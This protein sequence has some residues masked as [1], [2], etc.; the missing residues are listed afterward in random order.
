MQP[1]ALNFRL[2]F[3]MSFLFL[4][5]GVQLPF[6]PL[7]LADRGLSTAEI[8]AVLSGQILIRT[9][10]APLGTFL[11]DRYGR[12]ILL[13]RLG[14]LLCAA[15]YFLLD[16]MTGFAAIFLVAVLAS[17]FLS[18]VG[19]IAENFAIV[20]SAKRGLD[21]GRQRLWAS[22]SFIIGTL[23]S[24]FALEWLDTSRAV[25]LIAV[26]YLALAA[27]GFVLPDQRRRKSKTEEAPAIVRPKDVLQ[28]FR[29]RSFVIFLVAV[30]LA[31]ASHAL[32]YGFGSL[33]WEQLG[34]AKATIGIL[35]GIGVVAEVVFFFFSGRL[36]PS[37]MPIAL[38]IAGCLAGVLRWIVTAF[39]PA[40]WLLMPLQVLHA[41]TFALVHFGTLHFLMQN[42]PE[43]LRNS[44]QGLY[45]ACSAG[46]FMMIATAIAGPLFDAFAGGA[47]LAMAVM[48]AL[49][50]A[51]AVQ[52]MRISPRVPAAA[53]TSGS[54]QN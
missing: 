42:V 38:I 52:V 7:W 12:P 10:G 39:D 2:C 4:G 11:A 24:G 9:F 17:V 41:L 47:Y 3:Y 54:R 20:E 49:A 28:L 31:Q 33:H 25:L 6:L 18:P 19:P 26:S 22:V 13:M 34:H 45:A 53:D 16:F 46:L 36:I 50:A 35:W 27:A 15:S 37:F 48:S 21:Y 8:A 32:L 30:S 40:L 51:L 23:V 44:A 29:A 14:A 43:R 5:L 1:Q